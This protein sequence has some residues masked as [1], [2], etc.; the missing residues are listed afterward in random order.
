MTMGKWTRIQPIDFIALNPNLGQTSMITSSDLYL[1]IHG[2]SFA[3]FF[4][5]PPRGGQG[6]L[7]RF[8]TVRVLDQV[9]VVH[10]KT[11]MTLIYKLKKERPLLKYIKEM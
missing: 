10:G 6:V 9:H 4:L 3:L 8:W 11:F 2:E 5:W 7:P 1:E